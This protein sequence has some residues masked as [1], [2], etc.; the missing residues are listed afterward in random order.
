MSD[1]PVL[2]ERMGDWV[3]HGACREAVA[4][5]EADPSWW[6]PGTDREMRT[7]NIAKR[8]CEGCSVKAECLDWA[9]HHE[10]FGIWGGVG[11]RQREYVTSGRRTVCRHCSRSFA[12]SSSGRAYCS[13]ECNRAERLK[14]KREA[15]LG[16]AGRE[17]FRG[18]EKVCTVCKTVFMGQNSSAVYCNPRC[19]GVARRAVRRAQKESNNG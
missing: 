17:P 19:K 16:T 18:Y 15:K 12:A 5:G 4:R 8:I 13:E 6:F 9:I 10:Q 7:I 11:P 1:L 14:R 3:N 2:R